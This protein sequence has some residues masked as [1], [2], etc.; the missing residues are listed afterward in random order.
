MCAVFFAPRVLGGHAFFVPGPHFKPGTYGDKL[1]PGDLQLWMRAMCFDNPF[2][3]VISR[4]VCLRKFR[5]EFGWF[6]IA[7]CMQW[8][9]LVPYWWVLLCC[10]GVSWQGIG[11][12]WWDYLKFAL[13]PLEPL[14][15]DPCLMAPMCQGPS[16]SHSFSQSWSPR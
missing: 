10:V 11:N 7:S 13:K 6:C 16:I 14:R 8:K 4:Y 15:L 1:S 2:T 3:S 9:L 5:M 12:V